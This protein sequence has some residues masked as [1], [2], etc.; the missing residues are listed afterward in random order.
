MIILLSVIFFFLILR[1]AVTLFNFV[2]NPKLRRVSKRYHDKISILIPVRNEEENILFLLESIAEQEYRDYEVIILDDDSSDTT[3]DICTKFAAQ[4]HRFKVI[5]GLPLAVGWLGKNYACYQL[6]KAATGK[7][8]LFIDAD[9][10]IERGLLNSAIHRMEINNLAL[11]SLFANQEMETFG[12]K[13]VVPLMHYVLLN[14]LPLKLVYLTKY[15]AFAAASGQFMMFN[16]AVYRQYQWHEVVKNKV[17]EDIEIMRLVKGEGYKGE[18]L[19]ANGLINCRMY[20]GYKD[21]VDGFSKNF[22]AAFNYSI[23]GFMLYLLLIIGGPLIVIA[24]LNLQLIVFMCGIIMLGRSMIS[25][26][27]GQNKE[28]NMLLHPVQMFNLLVIGIMAIQKHLTRS[29][30]WKGRRV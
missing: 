6:A 15:P 12:E 19:L 11:L 20:T 7:Y 28:F 18:T 30:I 21:A 26:A 2:S 16:A 23:P 13:V 9:E 5:K 25:F 3:F 4:N 14:L 24:T 17:V 27:S 1:F 29:N 22:L 10:Q 8:L